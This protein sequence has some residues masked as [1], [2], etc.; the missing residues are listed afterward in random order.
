MDIKIWVD[1]HMLLEWQDKVKLVNT[2]E[3]GKP[4]LTFI[5]SLLKTSIICESSAFYSWSSYTEKN[6]L[7]PGNLEPT[8]QG[9]CLCSLSLDLHNRET[10]NSPL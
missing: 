4:F 7:S 9:P 6:I 8:D 2:R 5:M 1:V 10:K 3:W